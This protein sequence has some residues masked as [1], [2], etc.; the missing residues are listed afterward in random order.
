M[1]Q[2]DPKQ[3]VV[4]Y[5][6]RKHKLLDLMPQNMQDLFHNVALGFLRSKADNL[7]DCSVVSKLTALQTCARLKLIPEP[8]LG[9]IWFI[10]RY[11]RSIGQNEVTVQ[12]G[13]KGRIEL[14]RRS[15]RVSSIQT[16]I[17]YKNDD[18]EVWEEDEKTHIKVKPWWS[19]GADPP[20]PNRLDE[21]EFSWI[22]SNVEGKTEITIAH[23]TEIMESKAR[24]GGGFG[25][26]QFPLG[27]S[28]IVPIRKAWHTW[29]QSPEMAHVEVVDRENEELSDSSDKGLE[30]IP[31]GDGSLREMPIAEEALNPEV[32][33][34]DSWD[35]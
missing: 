16:Y 34:E 27:M 17:V 24:S 4:L 31:E 26:S 32:N 11:N 28:R 20:K 5:E 9:H 23:I 1:V 6:E 13:Y 22:R 30:S 19:I 21:V 3:A 10:P 15:G 14:A 7:I 8:G 12:V 35:F 29:P 18:W 33:K 25:W 2:V